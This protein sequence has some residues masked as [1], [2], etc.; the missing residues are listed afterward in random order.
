MSRLAPAI[1]GIAFALFFTGN[2]FAACPVLATL[3]NGTMADA[4]AVMGNFNH[5]LECPVFTGNVGIGVSDPSRLLTISAPAVSLKREEFAQMTVSDG[6][7]NALYFGNAT[8]VDG[9]FAPA[10]I[11]YAGSGT[12][13]GGIELMG[14]I[15]PTQDTSTASMG[16]VDIWASRTSSA[17][18]PLN[19]ALSTVTTKNL[20]SVRNAASQVFTIDAIGNV[21]IG[22]TAPT[23]RLEVSGQVKIDT[24]AS[25]ASTPVCENAGVLSSCSSSLRY[26]RDVKDAVFGLDDVMRMHPVTFKWKGRDESDFGLIAEDVA[27][28]DPLFVTYKNG[29][30]EGVKYAQLTAVLVSAIKEL[31]IEN[32][33]VRAENKKLKVQGEQLKAA[34]VTRENEIQR[35]RTQLA[36]VSD[37]LDRLTDK[38]GSYEVRGQSMNGNRPSTQKQVTW[39]KSAGV[40]I[41]AEISATAR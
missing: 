24:F 13:S 8:A 22:V 30:I 12:G 38:F 28:I 3:T 20:L 27:K 29:Q 37:K 36:D 41:P 17:T 15:S 32:D 40:G 39:I 9:V 6:G 1:M 33:V 11:G 31:K 34:D 10:L 23:Q 25:A 21:G 19:G 5:I 7:S 4:N 16:V 2:A 26:K 18:D 14:L 35:L